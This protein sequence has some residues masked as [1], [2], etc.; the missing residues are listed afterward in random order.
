MTPAKPENETRLAGVIVDAVTNS[1][2]TGYWA[3]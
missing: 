3:Q 1:G 2:V